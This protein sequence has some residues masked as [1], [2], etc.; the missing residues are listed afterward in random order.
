MKKFK[1]LSCGAEFD[2]IEEIDTHTASTGHS[3]AVDDGNS[4]TMGGKTVSEATGIEDGMLGSAKGY[5]DPIDGVGDTSDEAEQ[6][7]DETVT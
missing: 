2:S 4:K 7:D 1:C 3:M 5:S 6:N